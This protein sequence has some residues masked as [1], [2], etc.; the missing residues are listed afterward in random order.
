M[1][2]AASFQGSS[3]LGTTCA[4][5]YALPQKDNC[6]FMSC[7]LYSNIYWLYFNSFNLI[8]L[9]NCP[10]LR[11]CH[12]G[13]SIFLVLTNKRNWLI[14]W[15][16][17]LCEYCYLTHCCKHLTHLHKTSRKSHYWLLLYSK[18]LK[19]NSRSLQWHQNY[20]FIS[21]QNEFM[22]K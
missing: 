3:P 19:K 18:T 20:H 22:N 10:K 4:H 12:L 7:V 11:L 9:C 5:V 2:S 13:P 16:N 14:D 17:G 15:F 21:I 8:A 6:N 1:F